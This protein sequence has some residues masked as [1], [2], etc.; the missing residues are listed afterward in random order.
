MELVNRERLKWSLGAFDR[1]D[2]TTWGTY[3]IK[4]P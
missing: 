4:H 1:F 2:G 3:I